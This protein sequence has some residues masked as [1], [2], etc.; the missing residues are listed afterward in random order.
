MTSGKEVWKEQ[1]NPGGSIMKAFLLLLVLALTALSFVAV[2]AETNVADLDS[3]NWATRFCSY[4]HGVCRYS[5]EL[6]YS[7]A[8]CGVLW[9]LTLLIR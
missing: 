5:D 4:A 9:L 2:T 3:Y 1:T 8:G 6:R 7:A